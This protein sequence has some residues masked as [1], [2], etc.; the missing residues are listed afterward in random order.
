[1]DELY[2]RPEVKVAL[3]QW[4]AQ[5]VEPTAQETFV[6]RFDPRRSQAGPSTRTG[7]EQSTREGTGSS[8]IEIGGTRLVEG[9]VD[10]LLDGARHSP[11]EIVRSVAR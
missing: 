9:V 11:L 7:G 6:P 1:M 3:D 5:R 10:T 2:D 8:A 4:H